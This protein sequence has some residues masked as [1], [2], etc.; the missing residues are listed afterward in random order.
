MADPVPN[1]K[2]GT[3]GVDGSRTGQAREETLWAAE[4]RREARL[5]AKQFRR[6]RRAVRDGRPT[7]WTR[8]GAEPQATSE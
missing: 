3:G 1:T 5:A 4:L 7:T 2:R 6:I 8:C